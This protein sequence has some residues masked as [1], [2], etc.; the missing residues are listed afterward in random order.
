[1]KSLD[2]LGYSVCEIAIKTAIDEGL[3]VMCRDGKSIQKNGEKKYLYT[4]EFGTITEGTFSKT[5]DL[6]MFNDNL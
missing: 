3:I 5:I 2:I 6:F 1:M 4:S